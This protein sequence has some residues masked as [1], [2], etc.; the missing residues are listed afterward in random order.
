MSSFVSIASVS[1]KPSAPNRLVR[2][3]LAL[4]ARLRNYDAIID[5]A[6]DAGRRLTA[7]PETITSIGMRDWAHV[8]HTSKPLVLE[9]SWTRLE[10]RLALP[11]VTTIP[12]A[13]KVAA[14]RE[15][16]MRCDRPSTRGRWL[17]R[18]RGF[19]RSPLRLS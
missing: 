19:G 4:E 5:A 10:L 18:H 15:G 13:R 16:V 14:L 1:T 3:K 17:H 2:R 6:C 12:E 8:G 11:G 7:Q 9:P